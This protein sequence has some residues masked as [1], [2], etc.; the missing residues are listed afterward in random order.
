MT[1]VNSGFL[2]GPGKNFDL[3]ARKTAPK[4]RRGPTLDA[5]GKAR[6]QNGFLGGKID[7]SAKDGGDSRVV[8][9]GK[10]FSLPC[11]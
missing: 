10:N 11:F 9:R 8:A 5:V 6:G 3:A 1:Y 7:V 4:I 2:G